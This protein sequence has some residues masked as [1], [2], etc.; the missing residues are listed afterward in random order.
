M[1]KSPMNL[2]RSALE[3]KFSIENLLDQSKRVKLNPTESMQQA[4]S[5][6]NMLQQLQT[7]NIAEN[8]FILAVLQQQRSQE[9]NQLQLQNVSSSMPVNP[10]LFNRKP[11]RVRTAFTPLQL[12]RLEQE[13]ELNHYV[14]G[15]ER[16]ALAIKLGLS[17]L[18]YIF[19]R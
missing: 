11:K 3:N 18:I 13:F 17:K 8:P 4:I 15:Q 5:T 10:I 14:V 1:S 6:I 9:L 12:L 19:H 7:A 16:K 2:K